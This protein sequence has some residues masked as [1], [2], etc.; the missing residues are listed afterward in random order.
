MEIKDYLKLQIE[1]AHSLL[2][3]A[4]K[5]TPQ[6]IVNMKPSEHLNSIAAALAHVVGG[7]DYF[8]NMAIGG[9]ARIW[10][11]DAWGAKLG[12][13]SQL[14]RDWTIQ[15]PDLDAF[16]EYIKAVFAATDAYIQT[17]TPAEL[18]RIVKVFN[19]ERPVAN[20]LRLV[21]GHACGH[22]GEIATLKA[23][24]GVKGLPF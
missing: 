3:S 8:I 5:D 6:E 14:A 1:S 13:A 12:I 10:E 15:I 19:N 9:G 23:I 20:V 2:E 18:D 21:V 11:R 17:I 16:R 22:A 24:Q 7:E 4:L